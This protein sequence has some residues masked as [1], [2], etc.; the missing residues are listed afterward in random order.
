MKLEIETVT[1]N[2]PKGWPESWAAPELIFEPAGDDYVARLT[3]KRIGDGPY[4]IGDDW[5]VKHGQQYLDR[6][7]KS[8]YEQ[9][10]PPSIRQTLREK[11]QEQMTIKDLNMQN[12]TVMA[13]LRDVLSPKLC[14]AVSCILFSQEQVT[15]PMQTRKLHDAI[16]WL[17]E[18]IVDIDPRTGI[19]I[20]A[21]IERLLGEALTDAKPAAI[22]VTPLEAEIKAAVEGRVVSDELKQEPW[23]GRIL[24]P[25]EVTASKD[26]GAMSEAEIKAA[27][28]EGVR[29]GMQAARDEAKERYAARARRVWGDT[30][31]YNR[32]LRQDEED[33]AYSEKPVP[34][35]HVVA[36]DGDGETTQD[37]TT[38][39]AG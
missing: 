5:M 33:D 7:L 15:I 3:T 25:S 37:L 8:A 12:E 1:L 35:K 14:A 29:Q 16:Q 34:L 31:E 22:E 30:D 10:V 38:P 19:K 27:V 17:V 26:L 28:D 21:Q 6:M 23:N 36:P 11:D 2:P 20:K 9:L 32:Q 13:Q 24:D 4:T 39:N 18:E